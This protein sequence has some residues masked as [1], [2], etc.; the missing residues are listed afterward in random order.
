MSKAFF[1]AIVTIKYMCRICTE[2]SLSRDYLDLKYH[3]RGR[4]KFKISTI[5]SRII[6]WFRWHARLFVEMLLEKCT[7]TLEQETILKTLR[8]VH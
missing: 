5:V 4:E 3:L 6:F 8:D 1:T 2:D 7:C